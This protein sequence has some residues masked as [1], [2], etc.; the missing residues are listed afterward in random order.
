MNQI[1]TYHEFI[2]VPFYKKGR[3]NQ[4]MAVNTAKEFKQGH[5][6]LKSYK[7]AKY[8][9]HLAAS[10]QINNGL[11]PYFIRSLIRISDDRNY[12]AKLEDLLVVK[13]NKGK[14]MNYRNKIYR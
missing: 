3:Q 5:T 4:F 2:V 8:L 11:R 10:K 7:I 6:H 1:F 9:I 14:K 12:I 13:R